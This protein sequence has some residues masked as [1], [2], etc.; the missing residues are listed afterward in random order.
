MH[1]HHDEDGKEPHK[2]SNHNVEKMPV[3]KRVIL[4]GTS[5]LFGALGSQGATLQFSLLGL[6]LL[7][8]PLLLLLLRVLKPL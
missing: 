5:L 7:F 3:A 8:L 2:H 4:S 1:F 6:L